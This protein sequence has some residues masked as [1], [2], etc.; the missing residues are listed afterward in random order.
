MPKQ[1][2]EDKI[3]VGCSLCAHR[4][5][6]K[7]ANNCRQTSIANSGR[8]CVVIFINPEQYLAY[9]WNYLWLSAETKTQANYFIIFI[10]RI[11]K[12]CYRFEFQVKVYITDVP[13][14]CKYLYTSI[15]SSLLCSMYLSVGNLSRVSPFLSQ[16]CLINRI[17]DHSWISA[18]FI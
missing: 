14:V 13:I 7:D 16:R 8:D 5:L 9:S 18:C 2:K 12:L 3:G 11:V 17:N 6:K 1:S 10:T 4:I 15:L